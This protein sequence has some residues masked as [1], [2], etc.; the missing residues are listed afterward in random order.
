LEDRQRPIGVFDSGVGGLSVLRALCAELPLERFVY[1]SDSGHAPYGERDEVFVS[2]RAHRIVDFLIDSHN[3][4]SLVVACNTATAAAIDKLRCAHPDL[5]IIGVEPALKP[6]AT[7][8]LT[9]RVGVMATRSTLSSTKF[10][11]LLSKVSQ[12][13]P[14]TQFVLQPCDGL[15]SAIE[16]ADTVAVET[17]IQKYTNAMGQFGSMPG[18][19]DSLVLGCTHY[20]FAAETLRRFVGVDVRLLEPGVPVARQT[21]RL[22][23][24]QDL[25]ADATPANS[26]PVILG[27]TGHE[28]GLKQ[29]AAQWLNWDL[30]VS[31]QMLPEV[32]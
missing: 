15:A 22:L 4:K 2:S 24:T 1:M 16:R 13:Y 23:E 20:P 11:G 21:R 30:P 7:D 25:L 28:G 3:I 9:K 18:A 5:A 6:A 17:L 27:A 12:A 10:E 8:T 19:I 31:L 32:A 26:V 29:A 14:Q